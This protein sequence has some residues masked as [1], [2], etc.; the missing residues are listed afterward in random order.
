MSTL[1]DL[2]SEP[3]TINKDASVSD[4]IKKLLKEKITRLLVSDNKIESIVTERDLGFFLLSDQTGRNLD[5]ICVSEVSNPLFSVDL[6]TSLMKCAKTMLENYMGSLA[7]SN[8]N[9]I[10]GILT[11]TDLTR[12]YAEEFVGKKIVGEYMSPYYA[13]AYSDTPLYMVVKKMLDE[14][15]SR[16]ILRNKQ[17]KPEGILTYRDIIK[18]SLDLGNE[19]KIVDYSHPN[20]SVV[21]DRNG[22][23]SKNGFG[24]TTTAEQIMTSKI[25]SVNYNDDLALACQ[26]LLDH[27]IHGVGVVT[28][29]DNLFGILSK[30]DITRAIAFMH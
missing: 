26:M 16:I 19:K 9:S 22:F 11:K 15:I 1:K 29:K 12:Y 20:I 23:I 8:N 25:I 14:Q 30:T 28:G 7:I 17:E 24:R 13:W 27:K 3:I 18:I 5:D 4:V 10:V 2:M 6:S 21:F